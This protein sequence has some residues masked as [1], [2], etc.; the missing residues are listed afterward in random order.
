[1][2]VALRVGDAMLVIN[3]QSTTAAKN[4]DKN[5][6]IDSEDMCDSSSDRTANDPSSS[7]PYNNTINCTGFPLYASEEDNRSTDTCVSTSE[8]GSR[9]TVQSA[10]RTIIKN[11]LCDV[12]SKI[13]PEGVHTLRNIKDMKA[14]NLLNSRNGEVTY[15]L[16]QSKSRKHNDHSDKRA[17]VLTKSKFERLREKVEHLRHKMATERARK[18]ARRSS[19]ASPCGWLEK[20]IQTYPPS[21]IPSQQQ[22]QGYCGLK[23]GFL[24][25]D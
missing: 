16:K 10:R 25:A 15:E 20:S 17:S 1:M 4:N 5:M 13:F 7:T 19:C 9:D 14:S 12:F 3:V 24:L 6:D 21:S 18:K 11:T 2:S 22:R 8:R 23:R